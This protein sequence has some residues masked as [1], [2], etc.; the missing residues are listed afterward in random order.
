MRRSVPVRRRARFVR[1]RKTINA[2]AANAT[3]TA[4]AGLP[5]A[6]AIGGRVSVA[7]IEPSETY[8]VNQTVARKIA[9]TGGTTAGVRIEKTP[10]A[11]ATPLPPRKRNH[12]G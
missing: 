1:W 9:M 4:G 8:L 6:Y 7:S 12:T 10:Q 5:T 2:D 3:A 11:V